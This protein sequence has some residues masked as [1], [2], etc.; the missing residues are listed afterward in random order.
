M[1]RQI[2]INKALNG[3]IVNVGCQTLVFED[4]ERLLVELRRYFISPEVTEKEYLEKYGVNLDLVGPINPAPTLYYREPQA[5][6]TARI[7]P[8]G[9]R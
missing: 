1:M 2:T 3:F 8:Q 6:E 5:C 7:N 4:Y 9:L